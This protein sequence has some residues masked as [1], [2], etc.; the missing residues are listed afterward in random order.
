MRLYLVYFE[1]WEQKF[2]ALFEFALLFEVTSISI[3]TTNLNLE[4]GIYML[5]IHLPLYPHLLYIST[6][7]SPLCSDVLAV[8]LCCQS[9][10]NS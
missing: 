3:D 5:L 9:I 2:V 4:L 10:W 7:K 8:I 1:F 6:I